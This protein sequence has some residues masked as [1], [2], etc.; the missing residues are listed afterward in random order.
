METV[1]LERIAAYFG[2]RAIERL[3]I[4]QAPIPS[5][6]HT[7]PSSHA[8]DLPPS[9]AVIE[10]FAHIHDDRLREALIKLAMTHSQSHPT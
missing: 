8:P 2:Y 1:I 3:I 9:Q 10:Q 5:Q 7:A 4:I 6:Q